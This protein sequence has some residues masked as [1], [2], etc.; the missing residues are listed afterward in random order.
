MQM[1]VRVFVF[2]FLLIGTFSSCE[3]SVKKEE[4]VVVETVVVEP[5]TIP[6]ELEFVGVCQSSHLVQ[7]RSRVQG[8]LEEIT[9]KEGEFVHEN[10]LLFKIDPSE[11]EAKVAEVEANLEREK[12]IL[13]SAERAVERYK[14]LYEQKAASRKDFEDA[15]AQLLAQ[16]A[17]VNIY[18][19]KLDEAQLNLNYTEIRTPISGLTT[20]SRSQAG[21]LI[22]PGVNDLLTTV[23]IIDPIWVIVNVSDTY[24][25]ESTQEVAEGTLIVPK[26]YDFSV[27]LVLADGSRYP[28]MGQVSF[29]SPV[30]NPSTG[31]LSTRAIFPNPDSILKPGQFVRAEVIGAKRPDAII[32]PQSAVVQGEG[33]RFVYVVVSGGK[34]EMRNVVTGNWYQDYWII[35]SGLKKGDEVIYSGVNK[36]HDGMVVEAVRKKG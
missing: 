25:L 33:G 1:P 4:K 28:Y 35:K 26:N 12:A 30:L 21:T 20:N 27:S 14:P 18:K 31:T 24:F 15:T 29:I 36:V 9:Y 23:S 6:V 10:D 3:K 16:Q 22:T 7:I 17:T 5:Q 2:G 34:V 19:A 13:W 32:V 11:F 8:Y